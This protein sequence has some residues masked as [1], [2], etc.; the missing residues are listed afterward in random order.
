[1]TAPWLNSPVSVPLW[2][3][4]ALGAA[5]ALILVLQL[6]ILIRNRSVSTPNLDQL[7]TAVNNA[8]AQLKADQTALA[9][10]AAELKAS[11]DQLAAAS[12]D[13]AAL[14]ALTQ[15]LTAAMPPA[16]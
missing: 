2:A 7:T 8:A 13:D 1:M 5:L 10:S 11:Q 9:A 4:V 6:I 3:L 12:A 16:G 14:P 15:T